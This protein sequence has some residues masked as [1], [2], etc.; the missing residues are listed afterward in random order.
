MQFLKC[1]LALAAGFILLSSAPAAQADPAADLAKFSVFP[2]LDLNKLANG[3]VQVARGPALD[4]P[5][6]LSVQ[7][8]YLVPAP[9]AKTVELHKQWDP[10]RHPEMKVYLHGDLS[11]TP[12]ANDFSKMAGAPN[13][14]AV[15]AL[16]A[17]TEKLPDKGPLQMSDAEAQTFGKG[18]GASAVNVFWSH[19]LLQRATNFAGRGL[20]G[21][22]PYEFGGQTARV[23]EEVSR[24]LKEQPKIRAQFRPLIDQ[25]PLGGS[26]GAAPS[27]YWE[28]FDVDGT[29]AYSLGASYSVASGDFAQ[30]LDLQYYASSGYFAFITLYQM[31]PVTVGGKP[32]TLVW[33]G[34]SLSSLSL[35]ELHGIERVGSGAAMMKEIQRMVTYFQKDNGQ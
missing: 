6:D 12:R 34:D 22:P 31:W 5:R 13:N 1:W 32:A 11:A 4:F 2:P 8:L 26:T 17:A 33:R 29:A 35:S 28:L 27:Q 21:E 15:K 9:L 16:L 19:L 23:S 30:L 20:A 7:A 25:T 10:S 18:S 14:G 24:L 3:K